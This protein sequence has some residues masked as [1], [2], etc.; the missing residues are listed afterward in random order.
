MDPESWVKVDALKESSKLR[1]VARP[2]KYLK[3]KRRELLG[4]SK[5]EYDLDDYTILVLEELAGG[6][7]CEGFLLENILKQLKVP[8][9]VYEKSMKTYMQDQQHHS[10]H[11]HMLHTIRSKSLGEV[12]EYD[13]QTCL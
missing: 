7:I 10:K 12:E 13:E 11:S 5:S 1:I 3:D 4:K 9:S 6:I 2:F 8:M